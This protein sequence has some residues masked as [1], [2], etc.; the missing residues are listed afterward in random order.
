MKISDPGVVIVALFFLGLFVMTYSKMRRYQKD[1]LDLNKQLRYRSALLTGVLANFSVNLSTNRIVQGTLERADIINPSHGQ[2]YDEFT[3]YLSEHL[4]HPDDREYYLATYLRSYL[5]EQYADG[6][7]DITIEYRR[8]VYNE[9]HWVQC[10]LHL[11][12]EYDSKDVIALFFVNDINDR[13]KEENLLR[14]R[15]QR[16]P[17]TGLLNRLTY[18]KKVE[19]ILLMESHTQ[20]LHALLILDLDDFKIVN[21]TYGH[22]VG[23]FVIREMAGVLFKVFGKDDV[24]GR[25]GGD[26]FLVF[27]KNIPSA[28]Y[29][30]LKAYE[31]EQ[32]LNQKQFG[33]FKDLKL[34]SSIGIAIG[35]GQA[36]FRGYYLLADQATYQAK[37][38][39]KATVSIASEEPKFYRYAS[40]STAGNEQF[41]R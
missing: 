1:L 19:E 26:E 5:L 18:E 11:I 4:I 33:E 20:H 2:S 15:A 21:D 28:E 39:G 7:R 27:M 3:A 25:L 14:D 40:D 31:F 9:Y 16:D 29:A 38:A 8:L 6:N 34:T 32:A 22:M 41:S 13:K 35:S 36:D 17:L 37:D 30:E 10:S 12:Q 24:I 23:D